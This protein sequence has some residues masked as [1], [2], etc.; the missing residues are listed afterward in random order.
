MCLYVYF[1]SFIQRRRCKYS[2]A[3]SMAIYMLSSM[4]RCCWSRHISRRIMNIPPVRARLVF[5]SS[6]VCVCVFVQY[7][8][9][10]H[11]TH[12]QKDVIFWNPNSNCVLIM[13]SRHT[14]RNDFIFATNSFN[15]CLLNCNV[16]PTNERYNI[17]GRMGVVEAPAC[18]AI[19]MSEQ[20]KM[21]IV[22][23]KG[24]IC[25]QLRIYF[26]CVFDTGL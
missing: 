1:P 24:I 20:I 5:H 15:F 21:T 8:N 23:I 2:F 25:M 19:C 17:I 6:C 16:H 18:W 9:D 26:L 13:L 10:S 4:K 3:V 11:C 12:I 22:P 14:N 7:K